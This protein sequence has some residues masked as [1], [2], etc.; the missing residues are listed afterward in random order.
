MTIGEN[1]QSNTYLEMIF[2]TFKESNMNFFQINVRYK[3]FDVDN[4][5]VR[6]K[7]HYAVPTY[8]REKIGIIRTDPFHQCPDDNQTDSD[9]EKK[10]VKF[11]KTEKTT[12]TTKQQQQQQHDNI[13]NNGNN[14]R[15][16]F[17]AQAA[18][19]TITRLDAPDESR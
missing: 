8:K 10:K 14:N 1:P 18:I 5:T 19:M 7:M 3:I 4:L 9:L 12:T 15:R 2:A 6:Q 16:R 13:N 17:I 11:E